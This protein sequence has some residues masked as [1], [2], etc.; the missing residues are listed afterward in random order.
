[1]P[2]PAFSVVSTPQNSLGNSSTQ[3]GNM[4]L[5]L[6][7]LAYRSNALA[8]SGGLSMGIPTAPDTHVR[9]TDYSG[10]SSQGVATIQ[11]VRDFDIANETWA[12]SPFIA[13]L[14]T[15]TSNW[16]VQGFMQW[17]FPLN[18]SRLT[19]SDVFTQGQSFVTLPGNLVPPFAVNGHVFEQPLMHVDLNTGYWVVRN[20]N[21]RWINGIAPALELHYSTTMEN[22]SIVTLPGDNLFQINPNN[23]NQQIP[24][25]RSQVGN[26]RNRVDILD[27]T[28]ATTFLIA[29]RATLAT[30]VAFP[31]KG[32]DNRTYD[33]EFQVQFNYYFGGPRPRFAPPTF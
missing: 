10:S 12:L 31:L 4:Q 21:A 24:E 22:A 1:V 15:P 8:F 7:S 33:W 23:P 6:K 28:V 25:Q 19:Y 27:M 5:I 26:F 11:R 30:A 32:G 20:P 29:N 13:A 3:F 14:A 18:S 9:V 2:V 16:F 17:E